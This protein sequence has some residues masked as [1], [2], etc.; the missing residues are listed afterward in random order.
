M[1]AKSSYRFFP[2]LLVFL[3]CTATHPL[4]SVQEQPVLFSAVQD[5]EPVWQSITDG[6]WF[7]HAKTVSPRLEFWALRICLFSQNLGIVVRAGNEGAASTRVSSFVHDNNLLAGINATPFDVISSRE[8]QPIKNM[9]IIV[10]DG[11]QLAPA[12]TR[13]DALVFY[14][15]GT[16]AI[17]GQSAINSTENI[18]NAVGGFYQILTDGQAAKRTLNNEIR[19]PRSAAG[20][21][22]SG[23]NRYFYLLVID[24]RRSGS[25]GATEL[26][27]ALI[28]QLLGSKDGI[29]LDGGGSTTLALRYDD[30]IVRTVNTPIHGGIPGRERAVA[31][32]IGIKSVFPREDKVP[33]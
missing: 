1:K 16:A 11:V 12:N 3:S 14:T 24:G 22:I 33:E 26:E 27:T 23:T 28:L 5:I 6:L 29:N 21:S 17:V 7:F 9:G 30:G 15:D 2:L 13:Y 4:S 32:C 8:G 31:G 19:H 10:S 18:Q 20:L 25:A